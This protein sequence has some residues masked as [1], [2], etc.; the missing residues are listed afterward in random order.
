[1][2]VAGRGGTI[3]KRVEPL[4]PATISAPKLPPIL[5]GIRSRPK[6]RTPLITLTDDGDI[7]AAVKPA[8][9]P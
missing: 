3:L 8:D 7:P 5:G 6:P 1:M 9:K 2:W 4:S